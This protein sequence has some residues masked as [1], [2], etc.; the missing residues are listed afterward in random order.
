MKKINFAFFGTDDFSVVVLNELEKNSLIPEIIITAPD[1]P[2]GRNLVLTPPATKIW[3]KDRK[4]K[5]LQREILDEEFVNTICKEP[6]FDLFIVASFGKIIRKSI[7]SLPKKGALNVHP[8]L[9]PKYR[10]ASPIESQILSNEEHIGVSIML[11]DELMDHGPVLES[12]ILNIETLAER[13]YKLLSERL[14]KEGGKLLTEIIP[15]WISNEITPI[16][17]DHSKATFTKKIK[18]EDGEIKLADD[19]L[20]NYLKFLAFSSWPETY[21]FVTKHNK[22][23]R[24][25]IK[26]ASLENDTFVIKAVIPEGGKLM[27]FDDFKRGLEG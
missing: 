16:E 15:K 23:I 18:K 21:F 10:G 6:P 9:L 13:N 14:A 2:K 26:E 27:S 17:Q 22:Q 11:M 8:S 25:K 4:I 19:A 24:V 12:R 3:A 5:I 7:L 20:Q 1:R